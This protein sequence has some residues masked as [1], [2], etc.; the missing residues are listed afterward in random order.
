MQIL[1]WLIA[2]GCDMHQT[3]AARDTP[4]HLAAAS[5]HVAVIELLVMNYGL[6]ISVTNESGMTPLMCAAQTGERAALVTLVSYEGDIHQQEPQGSNAEALCTT[7]G[8]HG[9]A[10]ILRYCIGFSPL[11]VACVFRDA[12]AVGR[13]L[14]KGWNPRVPTPKGELPLDLLRAEFPFTVAPPPSPCRPCTQLLQQALSSWAPM[15]HHLYGPAFCSHIR[16]MLLLAYRLSSSSDQ[17]LRLPI[18]VWLHIMSFTQRVSNSAG[19]ERPLLLVAQPAPMTDIIAWHS[20]MPAGITA[21][22]TSADA[23]GNLI[24]VMPSHSRTPAV[25]LI[26]PLPWYHTWVRAARPRCRCVLVLA[27]LILIMVITAVVLLAS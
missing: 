1:E 17:Q 4:L 6:S 27:T 25:A 5:G 24:V 10:E 16:T 20:Q 21:G 13:L 19:R 18:E 3:N 11:Q 8:H 26:T 23:F 12:K 2:H 7:N 22:A 14:A 15:R 9:L